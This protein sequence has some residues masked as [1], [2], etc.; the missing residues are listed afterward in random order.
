MCVNLYTIAGDDLTFMF[1]I[2]TNH[3]ENIEQLKQSN[4]KSYMFHKMLTKNAY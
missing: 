4:I 1:T 2:E 3:I